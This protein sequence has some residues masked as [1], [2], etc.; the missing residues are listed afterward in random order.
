MDIALTFA[1]LC[2]AQSTISTF[3]DFLDVYFS[4]LDCL[5]KLEDDLAQLKAKNREVE[6]Q[7]N[8]LS[9]LCEEKNKEYDKAYHKKIAKV[10]AG[11]KGNPRSFV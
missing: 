11:V 3:T 4:E 5:K 10:S 9:Q 7:N 1:K 8:F 2:I 6:E